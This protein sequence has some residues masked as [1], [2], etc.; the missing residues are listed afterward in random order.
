MAQPSDGQSKSSA[1]RFSLPLL[2]CAAACAAA[3][4][5]LRQH[6]VNR[7]SGK[8]CSTCSMHRLC[9]SDCTRQQPDVP[10]G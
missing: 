9:L 6:T 4:T 3:P 5:P 2:F 7:S 8:R 1:G 10:I